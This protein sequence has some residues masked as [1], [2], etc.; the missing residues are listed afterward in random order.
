MSDCE[1]GRNKDQKIILQ[2]LA[3][4]IKVILFQPVVQQ[5]PLVHVDSFLIM[6]PEVMNRR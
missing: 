5:D 6:S 1:K 3:N 2:I 4:E